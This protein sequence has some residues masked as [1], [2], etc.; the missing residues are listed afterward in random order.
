M[1][2]SNTAGALLRAS[3]TAAALLA[4]V[5]VLPP[6]RA[7]AQG[8]GEGA[9]S[10]PGPDNGPGGTSC[11]P[12][13]RAVKALGAAPRYHWWLTATTPAR[14]RPVE[15]EE[16]VLDDDVYLTPDN[17]RWM[18]QRI[19]LAERVERVETELARTPISDCRLVGT[20]TIDGV[21]LRLYSYRQGEAP[22]AEGDGDALAK[23]IWVGVEDG[24]PRYFK[25]T[26]GPVSVAMRVR[27]D[28]VRSPLP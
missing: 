9:S 15:Q 21:P 13:I 2:S 16:V 10:A 11:E 14:R 8:G 18:K 5:L 28:D 22:L 17:G 19:V 23:R 7:A 3:A 12:V 6:S 4:A 24:L 26:Q 1:S 25:A 27:Y 20:D